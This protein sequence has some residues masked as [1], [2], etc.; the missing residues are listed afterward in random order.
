MRVAVDHEKCQGHAVCY[1]MAPELFPLDDLGYSAL[2]DTEVGEAEE[3]TVRRV[4]AA[5]PEWA[6]TATP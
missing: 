5:C 2:E 1:L 3:E 4:V 6:L